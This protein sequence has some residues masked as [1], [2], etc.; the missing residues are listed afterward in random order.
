MNATAQTTAE[1]TVLHTGQVPRAILARQLTQQHRGYTQAV[2][3]ALAHS[4]QGRPT[5]QVQP[6]PRHRLTPLGARL[7]AATLHELAVDS[8]VGRPV[9][10][11]RASAVALLRMSCCD[12]GWVGVDRAHCCLRVGGCDHVFDAQRWDAHRPARVCVGPAPWGWCKP[13]TGSGCG[14]WTDCAANP[15][16]RAGQTRGGGLCFGV[17][18]RRSA[19]VRG[20]NGDRQSRGRSPPFHLVPLSCRRGAGQ[21]GGGY[22]ARDLW[23]WCVG[24]VNLGAAGQST[25]DRR[26]VAGRWG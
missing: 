20:P 14:H 2:L 22:A 16:V 21:G 6:M 8:T 24:W 5:T 23:I 13:K 4:Q 9:E 25:T 26:R 3:R 12:T 15:G 18:V 11:S 7:T 19:E 1:T 10:V 17:G